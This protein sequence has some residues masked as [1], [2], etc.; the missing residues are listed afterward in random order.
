MPKMGKH[1]IKDQY[2]RWNAD[3]SCIR[4]YIAEA[5]GA[6][7]M[8]YLPDGGLYPAVVIQG[9]RVYIKPRAPKATVDGRVRKSSRHRVMA[10]CPECEKH[11]SVGRLHQH[12]CKEKK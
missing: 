2:N 9:I 6:P 12:V 7:A 4:K 8:D 1:I 10:I 11:L 3:H 5:I